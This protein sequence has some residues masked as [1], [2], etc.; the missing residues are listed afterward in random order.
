MIQKMG[1]KP[2]DSPWETE[3]TSS[4]NKNEPEQRKSQPIPFHEKVYLDPI[5]EEG[6]TKAKIARQGTKAKSIP[7]ISYP[8]EDYRKTIKKS[9]RKRNVSPLKDFLSESRVKGT[10]IY[11]VPSDSDT[12]NQTKRKDNRDGNASPRR[13]N[14]CVKYIKNK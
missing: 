3:P 10:K 7:T 4:T 9:R 12:N 13:D 5:N 11:N 6:K 8:R 2:P 1:A 14:N